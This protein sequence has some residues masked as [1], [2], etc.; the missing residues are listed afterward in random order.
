MSEVLTV[1]DDLG[2]LKYAG[3]VKTHTFVGAAT[4]GARNFSA[5]VASE[6]VAAPPFRR[7]DIVVD[8]V[9]H[10]G[11]SF[12]VRVFGNNSN[13]TAATAPTIDNGYLG[14]F[15]VFGHGFCF[16]DAGHCEVTNRGAAKTDL[17]DPH[18]LTPEQKIV[19]AT[20]GIK[21]LIA[22]DGALEQV[23]LVPIVVGTIP[24]GGDETKARDILKYDNVRVVT[25]D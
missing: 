18:P 4:A 13:A 10:S 16:G 9:D 6:T 20:G 5:E 17:R 2:P 3:Q 21:S 19:V 11:P 22:R 25:Y 7:A 1:A 14:S 24:Q 15:H 12:E 8:G 23:S